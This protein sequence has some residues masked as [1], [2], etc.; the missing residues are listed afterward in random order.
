[1]VWTKFLTPMVLDVLV[2][3]YLASRD[4][5]TFSLQFFLL[6][7]EIQQISTITGNMYP[8][9]VLLIKTLSVSSHRI[10]IWPEIWLIEK[11]DT[12]Y[13][14]GLLRLRINMK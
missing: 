14:A 10:L 5:L 11:P 9:A 3:H 8:H 2:L 12:A 13:P 4:Q 6:F 7:H 1:M